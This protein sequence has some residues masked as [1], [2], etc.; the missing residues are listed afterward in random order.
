M[1]TVCTHE[2]MLDNS[3]KDKLDNLIKTII[4]IN[5]AALP[6]GGTDGCDGCGGCD[7]GAGDVVLV[8]SSNLMFTPWSSV[9]KNVFMLETMC[10]GVLA[11]YCTV[12]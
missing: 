3:L 7:A 1:E 5:F 2:D 9:V 8:T 6:S 12:T 4:Y 10:W 11:V